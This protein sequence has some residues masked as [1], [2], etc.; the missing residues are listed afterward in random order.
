MKVLFACLGIDEGIGGLEKFNQR[1]AGCLEELRGEDVTDWRVVSLRDAPHAGKAG[2]PSRLRGFGRNRIRFVAGFCS[3]LLGFRP[4]VVIF[5]HV[6][7]SGLFPLAALLRPRA[8]RMLIVHG[9]EVWGEPWRAIRMPERL[10]VNRFVHRVASVSR[11]TASR[12]A[13]QYAVGQERFVLLPNAIDVALTGPIT[14]DTSQSGPR[15]LTV[16]RMNRVDE[17][18]G[19]GDVIQA[20]PAILRRFPGLHYDVIGGGDSVG[21]Y[22]RLAREF[23]VEGKVSFLGRVS[24]EEK[25]AAFRR[26]SLFVLPSRKEGFGI[27]FLEAWNYALPVIGGIKDAAAEVIMHGETGLLVDGRQPGEIAEAVIRLLGDAAFA[28]RLGMSGFER[29]RTNY[30]QD[31]FRNN[32]ADILRRLV[33]RPNAA[34]QGPVCSSMGKGHCGT[35]SHG[36]AQKL[37]NT[38]GF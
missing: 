38:C 7:L 16:A 14:R 9:I 17:E 23:G 37:E 29:L 35:D 25:D 27:V 8:R 1:L 21:R 36:G 4:D 5:G 34:D 15:M 24:D 26:A 28:T 18:K 32:L 10:L 22:Q 19:V 12:M 33:S 20:L 6:L 2:P 3:A 13:S 31:N 30:S 11:F